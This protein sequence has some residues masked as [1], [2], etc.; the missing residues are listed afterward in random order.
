MA[1]GQSLAHSHIVVIDM[2]EAKASKDLRQF[3][4]DCPVTSLEGIA[5]YNRGGTEW[6]SKLLSKISTPRIAQA[7]DCD[8]IVKRE[9]VCA[10]LVLDRVSVLTNIVTMTFLQLLSTDNVIFRFKLWSP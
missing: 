5:C 10:L 6:D 7:H 8:M 3:H 2:R 4:Q 1:T 9:G